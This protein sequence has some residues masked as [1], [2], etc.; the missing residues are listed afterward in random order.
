[1][2]IRRFMLAGVIAGVT[3]LI[4][5]APA[6]AQD[7]GV[8]FGEH[9]LHCVEDA[10][11]DNEAAIEDEDYT[12]FR[13]ALEDCEKAPSIISPATPE[14]IWGSVAFL[15]V[16]VVLIKFAFPALRKSLADRQE[17]IRGDL[18]GAERARQEAEAE[19]T[20]YEASLGDARAEANR[21]VEEAREAAEQV[22]RDLVTRAE[23][24]AAE[25]RSRAQQD[26]QL[27]AERAMSDLQQRVGEISIELAERI[28]E[29]N[30][31][32]DTQMALV[33]SYISSVGSGSAK[34]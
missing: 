9:L 25:I 18:E 7:P 23:T 5:A 10:I 14:L 12:G 31:D 21:I 2:R 28:V 33:E 22:R 24:D 27:A 4:V 30:L 29:R 8:K 32:K 19:K 13:N 17:K 1:M 6:S 20:R 3:V 15:I 16:A 26:A 34:S 11:H